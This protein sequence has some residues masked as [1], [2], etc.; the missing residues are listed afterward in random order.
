[1]SGIIATVCLTLGVFFSLVSAV[2]VLRMP[3]VFTRLHAS[4]KAGT[5]GVSFLMFASVIHFAELGVTVRAL[6]VIVFLFLTAP[7]AAHVI[8]RAAYTSRVPIWSRT[9]VDELGPARE[10]ARAESEAAERASAE[11]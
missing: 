11:R 7:I 3:D 9:A 2:G 8:A 1:M 10:R 6:L 4:T 5:L